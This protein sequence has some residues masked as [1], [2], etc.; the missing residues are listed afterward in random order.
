MSK[1]QE[2]ENRP[3]AGRIEPVLI[4]LSLQAV[5]M[6]ARFEGE[7]FFQVDHGFAQD[8]FEEVEILTVPFSFQVA[9]EALPPAW[10]G[11]STVISSKV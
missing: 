5:A 11:T 6:T 9:W 3:D 8:F 7:A 10:L 1:L 2:I 4:L